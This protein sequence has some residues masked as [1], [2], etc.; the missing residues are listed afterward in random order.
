MDINHFSEH[1][2]LQNLS[3]SYPK[4][5]YV[6]TFDNTTSNSNKYLPETLVVISNKDNILS[7]QVELEENF[8]FIMF[9]KFKKEISENQNT[10][11]FFKNYDAEDLKL[12]TP[13]FFKNIKNIVLIAINNPLYV[14]Y[15]EQEVNKL[16]ET[17]NKSVEKFFDVKNVVILFDKVVKNALPDLVGLNIALFN[18]LSFNDNRF[19]QNNTP[20]SYVYESITMSTPNC[21]AENISKTANLYIEGIL[22]SRLLANLPANICTPSYVAD[23]ALAI[24]SENPKITAKILKKQ[25]LQKL[26][27]NAF[28]AVSQGSAQEPTMSV[29]TYNGNT[30]SQEPPIVLI[31]K[32]LTFDSGGISLKPSAL[33]DEMMFDKCGAMSVLATIRTAAK[34]SLPV[35]LIAI[36]SCSENLPNGNSYKPGDIIYTRSGQTIEVLN[37]DAEGRLVLCDTIDYADTF[38][39]KAIID[40]AT[41]TGACLISLGHQTTGLFSNNKNLSEKFKNASLK[42]SDAV[43]ELPLGIL[44]DEMINARFGDIANTGGRLAGSI[45][46]AQFLKRFVKNNTPWVH[47]DIAG[48]A[49]ISGNKKTAT[50]RPVALLLKYLENI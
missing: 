46:A 2:T 5:I 34:L 16:A 13:P 47:L 30:D 15:V 36:A 49:W 4:C 33:M 27:M 14:S 9:N 23:E 48:S 35:N 7:N 43:W 31:G 37:T 17:I 1:K 38:K 22:Y 45:T 39:P 42:S 10:F 11:I 18:N 20:I 21:D 40:V 25:D 19:K 29:L 3:T 26:N 28:L 41:L 24:A 50:G 6:N 8:N 44:Y 12:K 32:G